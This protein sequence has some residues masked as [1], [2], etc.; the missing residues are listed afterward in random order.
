MH[1]WRST[2]SS[3]PGIKYDKAVVYLIKDR[4]A[5]LAFYDLPAEHWKH[6]RTTDEIDKSFLL[7][8]AI[9]EEH[10]RPR[11]KEPGPRMSVRPR[12]HYRRSSLAAPVRRLPGPR[13]CHRAP[14][15]DE[16]FVGTFSVARDIDLPIAQFLDVVG[17]PRHACC[18]FSPIQPVAASH[19]PCWRPARDASQGRPATNTSSRL[20]VQI[21]LPTDVLPVLSQPDE[22]APG[23]SYR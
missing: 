2:L 9:L 10:G 5:L 20:I 17:I 23:S 18:P 8:S 19:V 7:R 1:S 6:L 22:R 4:D 14:S 15:A 3:R 11:G 16:L 13:R 12:S 21:G